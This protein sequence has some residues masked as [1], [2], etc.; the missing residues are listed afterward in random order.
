MK[1]LSRML[2]A[3]Q[4]TLIPRLEESYGSLTDKHKQLLTILEVVRIEEFVAEGP[5]RPGPG[6]PSYSRAAMARAFVAK[7]FYNLHSTRALLELLRSTPMLRRIC[8]FTGHAAV[9]HESVF[10]RT[11]EEFAALSLPQR[12]HEALVRR[13]CGKRLVGHLCRDSTEIAAREKAVKKQPKLKR[14]RGRPRKGEA[15][16]APP[17]IKRQPDMS[18]AEMLTNLPCR[19]DVG[20]KLNSKGHMSFWT[21]YKLHV[22]TADGQIP[23]S[24]VLTSATVHDSQVA[25]PLAT[26]SAARVT[27]LYDLMDAAYD[28]EIIRK[29][30]RGLGHVPIIDTNRRSGKAVEMEPASRIRF[31]ERTNSER[32]N[33]RLKDEFGGRMVRVRG[34]A[35]VMAHLMFGILALT[36]DQ[37]LR[38]LT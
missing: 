6:R 35:K 30:S 20:A 15:R 13:H 37:L 7:A 36:G 38:L 1:L 8:G 18:L 12:V 21:G 34:G 11:F 32:V 25:I 4:G 22:D 2:G 27:S 23:I 19:C 24:C 26:M 29:H 9:P 14:R 17:L 33:G 31:R 28:A 5:L 10:S 16:P 3:I